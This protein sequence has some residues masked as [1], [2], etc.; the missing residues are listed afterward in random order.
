MTVPSSF[1]VMVSSSLLKFSLVDVE[2]CP[3]TQIVAYVVDEAGA[4]VF[5]RVL[6]LGLTERVSLILT[7]ENFSPQISHVKS[8]TPFT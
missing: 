5:V 4:S 6:V 3:N 2:A 8:V 1:V 7:S